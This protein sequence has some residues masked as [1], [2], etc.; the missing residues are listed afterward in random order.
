MKKVLSL[1]LSVAMLLT[2]IPATAFAAEAEPEASGKT[3]MDI[4]MLQE[5][6]DQPSMC[7]D[8]FGPQAELT[9][10]GKNVK[11]KIFVIN[12]VP[13]PMFEGQ[14]ADGT[15]KNFKIYYGGEEY[16]AE[17][18]IE[19]KPMVKA[20]GTNSLFGTEEGKEYTA[21]TVTATLP[22]T[23]LT[24]GG[25]LTVKTY[26]NVFL[27]NDVDF[28]MKISNVTIPE[29]DKT[30]LKDMVAEA[31]EKAAKT[32]M[33][34]EN[35]IK[36]LNGEIEKAETVLADKDA[37]EESISSVLNSLNKA[38]TD[39]EKIE[40]PET[41]GT[42]PQEKPEKPQQDNPVKP[43]QEK[44]D[45]RN[46]EDGVYAVQGKMYKP[47]GDVSMSDEGINHNIKLTVKDGKY[48]LTMDFKGISL[49]DKFGYL[50]KLEYFLSGYTKNEYKV[51]EGPTAPATVEQYIQDAG[52]KRAEDQYGTDYPAVVTFEMIPE[53]LEDGM[54]P[55]Q[56]T[57]PIMNSIAEG[58]GVQQVYLKLDWNS[59]V[60]TTA[61][62]KI[63][64]PETGE[65]AAKDTIAES[66]VNK[67]TA[68]KPD[69]H[70]NQEMKPSAPQKADAPVTGD[71]AD[72]CLWAVIMLIAGGMVFGLRRSREK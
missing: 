19:T 56:V 22:K 29:A 45:Y 68:A 70:Q 34:T 31:E 26:V 48:Y 6:K 58:L 57:V 20:R 32:D 15:V 42:A 44:P 27:N 55:L 41:E 53:A 7:N 69:I 43:E 61:D 3:T 52:G 37:T 11:V 62:D 30:A 50:G 1:L 51:P 72:L 64:E 28:R 18:D 66:E 25:I 65:T 9:S 16:L 39:L 4:T 33:Y 63:F 38:V 67:N 35:T 40:K 60:R 71:E 12:P 5:T 10:A 13:A 2:G 46:L 59:I 14:G 21:Q 8:L 36:L 49:G 47:N 17:S 23:A 54:I 24:E